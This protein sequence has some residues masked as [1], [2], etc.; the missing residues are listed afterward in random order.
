ML[1]LSSESKYDTSPSH[2]P[3]ALDAAFFVFA[4]AAL[5]GRTVSQTTQQIKQV[6]AFGILKGFFPYSVS[7]SASLIEYATF[8]DP[9][10]SLRIF[11]Q[12]VSG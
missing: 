12:T 1:P 3:K 9:K 5:V 6:R 4:N 11:K 7:L 8:D 2:R 10:T